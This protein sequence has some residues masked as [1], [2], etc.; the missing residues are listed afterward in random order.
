MKYLLLKLLGYDPRD[1]KVKHGPISFWLSWGIALAM[2]AIM[3]IFQ[4]FFISLNRSL[5]SQRAVGEREEI[6]EVCEEFLA[7]FEHPSYN[8]DYGLNKPRYYTDNLEMIRSRV[9]EC[10]FS[11][12][13]RMDLAQP[14]IRPQDARYLASLLVFGVEVF[15]LFRKSALGMTEY[16]AS[17]FIDK[18]DRA[19]GATLRRY[20]PYS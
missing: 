20:E 7:V 13:F 6:G 9:A 2:L 8:N 14:D 5:T 18:N 15:H 16:R 10:D 19:I 12:F 17:I 4:D 1:P 11:L 3:L